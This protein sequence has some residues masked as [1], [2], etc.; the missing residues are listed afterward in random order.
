MAKEG[1]GLTEQ[2]DPRTDT[3]RTVDELERKVFDREPQDTRDDADH[4]DHDPDEPA[5]D[6]DKDVED[7]PGGAGEPGGSAEEPVD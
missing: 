6:Q 4:D 7:M 3:E 5:F 2:P 1:S